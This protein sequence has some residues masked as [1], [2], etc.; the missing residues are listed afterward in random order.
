VVD[1]LRA[2][3]KVASALLGLGRA[4]QAEP[5]LST[6][7]AGLPRDDEALPQVAWLLS[8]SL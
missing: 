4:T 2:R 5:V 8:E 7:A 6:V 1:E 3:R